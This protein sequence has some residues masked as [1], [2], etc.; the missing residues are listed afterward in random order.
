MKWTVTGCFGDHEYGMFPPASLRWLF[1]VAGT[2]A[3]VAGGLWM[4]AQSQAWA[5]PMEAE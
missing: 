4:Q 2:L 1:M 5:L 3:M